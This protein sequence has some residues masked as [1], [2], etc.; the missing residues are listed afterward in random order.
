MEV[1]RA[2]LVQWQKFDTWCSDSRKGDSSKS[3]PFDELEREQEERRQEMLQALRE[4]QQQEEERRKRKERLMKSMQFPAEVVPEKKEA[5]DMGAHF[6]YSVY[7]AEQEAAA[8]AEIE[9]RIEQEL[10]RQDPHRNRQ[11]V[12]S[13]QSGFIGPRAPPASKRHSALSIPPISLKDNEGMTRSLVSPSGRVT[14]PLASTPRSFASSTSGVKSDHSPLWSPASRNS[15]RASSRKAGGRHSRHS[16]SPAESVAVPADRNLLH[17]SAHS[18]SRST[19]SLDTTTP[20]IV[21]PSMHDSHASPTSRPSRHQ[22]SGPIANRQSLIATPKPVP[23][24]QRRTVMRG[25]LDLLRTHIQTPTFAPQSKSSLGTMAEEDMVNSPT[26]VQADFH[27]DKDGFVPGLR[28]ELRV[29]IGQMP[30]WPKRR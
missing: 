22:I 5:E 6:K 13:N 10:Q 16:S 24:R 17:V 25:S 7:L 11:S 14:T 28:P 2:L 3:L 23:A 21:L 1:F 19:P 9:Q 4:I 12:S 29:H 8:R 15:S 26:F 18:R 27:C 30:P 20:T